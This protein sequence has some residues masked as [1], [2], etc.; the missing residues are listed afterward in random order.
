VPLSG[1]RVWGAVDVVRVAAG[2]IVE[3]W[4]DGE[5]LARFDPLFAVSVTVSN[6]LRKTVK[7]ERWTYPPGQGEPT[8]IAHGLAV[9]VVETGE[10]WVAL[11]PLSTARAWLAGRAPIAPSE[12]LS[13]L[14]LE[15]SATLGAG[16]AFLVPD[17]ARVTIGNNGNRAASALVLSI[18]ATLEATSPAGNDV[19][20][21]TP[22]PRIVLSKLLAGG[23]AVELPLGVAT[24]SIGRATLPVGGGVASHPV[25]GVEL[26]TVE[27]GEVALAA[28]DDAAWVLQGPNGQSVLVESALL[29]AGEG[30][31]VR[32]CRTARYRS[33]ADEP[34]D[35]LLVTIAPIP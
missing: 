31:L 15:A 7:L 14:A 10:L 19:L 35:L 30:V 13:P 1:E 21:S 11:D 12:P 33:V 23:P 24:I 29:T 2:A 27:S 34:L 20:V 18:V 28:S 6:P 26:L 22:A 32:Q 25:A 4:G 5:P 16:T 17:G 8:T 3:R 9:V